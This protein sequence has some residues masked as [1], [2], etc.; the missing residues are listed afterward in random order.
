MTL[1]VR[2]HGYGARR[3]AVGPQAE[4]S[5]SAARIRYPVYALGHT[6][7]EPPNRSLPVDLGLSGLSPT[8]DAEATSIHAWLRG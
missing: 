6:I 2:V 8:C 5:R 7:T 3:C 4:I 1:I